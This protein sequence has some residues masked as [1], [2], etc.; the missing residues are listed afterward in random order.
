MGLLIILI[1]AVGYVIGYIRAAPAAMRAFLKSREIEKLKKRMEEL[2]K[3]KP[4]PQPQS[5]ATE[6]QGE[7]SVQE[8]EQE[9]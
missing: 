4:Q 1:F 5:E 3:S 8:K 2:E 6:Y 7:K 9:T